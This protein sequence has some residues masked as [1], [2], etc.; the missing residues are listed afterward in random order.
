MNGHDTKKKD[1]MTYT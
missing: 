1:T